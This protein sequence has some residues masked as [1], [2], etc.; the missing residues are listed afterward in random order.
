LL[1][2]IPEF[3]YV[4]DIYP[5][6][7]RANT[8]FKLV[9]QAFI[10]LSLSSAYIIAYLMSTLKKSFSKKLFLMC[11]LVLLV[12]VFIYPYYAIKS[13]YADLGI[14]NG[15]NGTDY[16]KGLY[17]GDL[18]A[19]NFLNT[20]VSGQPVILE[21]QGDSYTD[22]ARISSNTGLP[23][24]LGWTVHEWLWRGTY[25][26]PAPRI[27]EV[28]TI[29]EGDAVTAVPLLKKYHV[30]YVIIGPLE[31]QKYPLLNEDKF[32]S[33]GKVIFKSTDGLTEIFAL[34]EQ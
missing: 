10:M 16:L 24:V 23:T 4:K 30:A 22:Y 19:I 8:M 18:E 13:Y 31:H 33:L 2:I 12:L 17:P 5:Q 6:H 14:Y 3:I 11:T 15:L 27:Q 7:Y 34:R 28:K 26:V 20:Y 32:K 21:A 25:S 1:I 29:Y 9:Y